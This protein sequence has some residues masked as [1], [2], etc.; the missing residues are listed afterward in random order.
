MQWPGMDQHRPRPYSS[1]PVQDTTNGGTVSEQAVADYCNDL[2]G[3]VI[4]GTEM[5]EY[6]R[7]SEGVKWC[8]TCRKRH[9]FWWVCM[10]PTG[11]SYYGPTAHM[12]GV[13]QHCSD[14][15][16]G[17]YREAPDE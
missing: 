12:E 5:E 11:I 13:N 3:V 14:L 9:E 17:W 8:F 1:L 4:C 16:P 7:R 6:S 10:A 2:G 15:F